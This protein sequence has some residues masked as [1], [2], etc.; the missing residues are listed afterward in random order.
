MLRAYFDFAEEHSRDY[1]LI[2]MTNCADLGMDRLDDE[3][4]SRA[5]G[6]FQ[7]LVD[8]IR[9]CM[10]AGVFAPAGDQATAI[11]VWSQTHGLASL[12]LNGQLELEQYHALQEPST[13]AIVRALAP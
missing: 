8:R 1:R 2:F 7:F 5:G 9:E 6:T 4:R 13:A 11:V 3:A 12:W 10:A